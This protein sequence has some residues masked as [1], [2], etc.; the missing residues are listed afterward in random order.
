MK[1]TPFERLSLLNQFRILEQVDLNNASSH[2]QACEILERGYTIEY[3]FTILQGVDGDEVS[4]Q[5]C[6]EVRDVL[7]M[8]RALKA[9]LRDLPTG[10]LSEND[11]TFSGFDGND[12]TKHYAYA[13]FLIEDQK[14]WPE[15]QALNSHTTMLGKYRRMLAEWATCSEKGHLTANEVNGILSA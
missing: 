8:Y 3:G 5:D 13:R 10:T 9:A 2:R 11:A 7:D 6:K 1:L 12:E 14:K 4:E 15:S